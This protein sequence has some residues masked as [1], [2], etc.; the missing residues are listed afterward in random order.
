[1]V[2]LTFMSSQQVTTKSKIVDIFLN[3]PKV[4]IFSDLHL[5]VHLDSTTWHQV[6]LDWCDWFVDEIKKKDIRDIL[7]LGDFYHHRSDISVSTLHVAGLILDK[8]SEFNIVMIV[9]N[10]D[11]YYKDRSDINSLSILNGRKNVTVISETTTTTLFGKKVSFIPWGGEI[12]NLPKTDA[13]FGHL[14]IE[15]F[16][17]NSFKTCDHGAKSLDLL[18]KAELIMSGH[19]HLRDERIYNEG[20]IIYVGNPFE[21]DFGDLGS[22][23]G[24]YILDFETLKYDF[25][26]NI[27]SPI[28]KKI[29]LTELT[30]AKSLTGSDINQMVNG[31]FV[32]FVVD[33]KANS[34][35]IDALIQK[36][37]VYKP[38]SFTT[39]YTYTESAYVVDDKNYDTTGVDMQ[40]T[41]EEFINVLDIEDKESII[42]YCADLYKRAS[43]V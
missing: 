40:A 35:A 43:Q 21:M 34:D 13:I 25:F 31:N 30:N 12:G 36:F 4:A 11:A 6:A 38:L 32:K 1:M 33:K 7:F 41:I 2:V 29:S 20:K 28:H 10:H 23:K 18:T 16:K 17:M 14:E 26:V 9:G 15:S 5:G 42:T 37:S 8:L 24:Y 3:K 22:S 27:I 19:F 39:D